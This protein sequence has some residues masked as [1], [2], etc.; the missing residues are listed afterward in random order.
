MT[1]ITEISTI[2]YN[3]VL[4]ISLFIGGYWTYIK[5]IKRHEEASIIVKI[6]KNKIF[7]GKK[8][9]GAKLL[10]EVLIYNNG[11]REL[12]L[13][14]DY[15]PQRLAQK[16]E[17]TERHYKSEVILYRIDS[18]H[19]LI[20]VDS[21]IG[22]I[23]GNIKQYTGRLRTGVKISIPYLLSIN[24]AGT[25]LIEYKI[26]VNM[27][28]YYKGKDFSDSSIKTWSTRTYYHVKEKNLK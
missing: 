2:I 20:K 4:T 28:R 5:F 17:E 3:T 1:I 9:S 16:D 10:V 25:Y 22:L 7:K 26:D 21:M 18:D 12:M 15:K 24:N 14:Y 13:Y 11:H 8:K 23:S 6:K 19:K 27:T